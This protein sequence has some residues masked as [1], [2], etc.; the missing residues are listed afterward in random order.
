MTAAVLVEVGAAQ[1]A[2]PARVAKIRAAILRGKTADAQKLFEPI[3]KRYKAGALKSA[4]A[5]HAAALMLVELARLPNSKERYHDAN[6]LFFEAKEADPKRAQVFI[7]WGMLYVEKY[8]TEE[9]AKKFNLALALEP[10]NVDAIAGLARV[11]YASF[12]Y[13][14]AIERVG[15]VLAK[16]PR[17]PLAIR[18]RA[19]IAVNEDD[20]PAAATALSRLEA[21]DPRGPATSGLRAAVAYFRGDKQR[22][23][24]ERKGWAKLGP[25]V[26]LAAGVL[27]E[28]LVK[29]FQY[30]EIER[31]TRDALVTAPYS[32]PLLVERGMN[33][34]R[35]GEEAMA[36]KTLD[37]AH[38]QDPFHQQ[39]IAMLNFVEKALVPYRWH[40][41]GVL[42]LRLHEGDTEPL[43]PLVGALVRRA[44]DSMSRRFAY[45]PERVTLELFKTH[46]EFSLRTMGVPALGALGVCFGPV[47]TAVAP[48]RAGARVNWGQILWHELSHVFS[49]ALSRGRAP[50]WFGEGLAVVEE[51]EGR[52]EW[53]REMSVEM[54]RAIARGRVLSVAK[55]TTAFTRARSHADMLLA[56]HQSSR[57]VAFIKERWGWDAVTRVL[58]VFGDGK[59]TPEVVKAVTGLEVAEFDA[60]FLEWLK[61]SVAFLDGQ[62]DVDPARYRDIPA[63]RKAATDA[64][65]DLDRQAALAAA[66]HVHGAHQPA[67]AV[68]ERIVGRD[69]VH[70]LARYVAGAAASALGQFEV[71]KKNFEALRTAGVDGHLLRAALGFV[72]RKLND[73]ARAEVEYVKARELNPELSSAIAVVAELR[74]AR[75]EPDG[76]LSE[77][78]RLAA[79]DQANGKAMRAVLAAAEKQKDAK[80]VV[81]AAEALLF[82]EPYDAAVHVALARARR[83]AGRLD[84]AAQ[85][86]ATAVAL[87]PNAGAD[88]R[89]EAAIVMLDAGKRG[90]A[91]AEIDAVLK[92]D[93]EHPVAKDLKARCEAPT[94]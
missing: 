78:R 5:L 60:A 17:H 38:K 51:G 87:T 52:P 76:A 50:R 54:H 83:E 70:P 31:V 68:A 6:R 64:P 28:H 27:L 85:S 48:P 14:T 40:E 15:R 33:A 66:L 23:E 29:R 45:A 35:L 24:A 19:E 30:A 34:M 57:V 74:A 73:E 94:P 82:L 84:D 59:T 79:F 10:E 13:A 36:Q 89:V 11:A 81:D 41:D 71:A 62:F 42:R 55:L 90:A 46:Q 75:G 67:L 3:A 91:C 39:L 77:W 37:A 86:F 49:I 43:L 63:I 12:D 25:L 92:T 1:S 72:Y 21:A 88:L 44:I 22:Y 58:T 16:K 20:L 26:S 80:A 53:A 61:K 93:A 18:T 9:A 7:D 65:A 32:A 56:Y 47:V 69:V 2:T 8:D 4:A